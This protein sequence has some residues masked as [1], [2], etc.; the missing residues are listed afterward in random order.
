MTPLQWLKKE[1]AHDTT[2]GDCAHEIREKLRD[3]Q[4]EIRRLRRDVSDAIAE[5]LLQGNVSVK[6]LSAI[7]A[8][9]KRR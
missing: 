1:A 3:Q 6:T 2:K 9:R 4:S 8:P 7:L 5:R